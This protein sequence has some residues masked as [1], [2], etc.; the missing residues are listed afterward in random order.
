MGTLKIHEPKH[1]VGAIMK[2]SPVIAAR[3]I[4]SI[5]LRVTKKPSSPACLFHCLMRHYKLVI[6]SLYSLC[7]A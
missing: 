2:M 7:R 1:L 3:Q 4:A 5:V 6:F